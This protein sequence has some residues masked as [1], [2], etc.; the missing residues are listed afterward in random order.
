MCSRIDV[1]TLQQYNKT[2]KCMCAAY[3]DALGS[4]MLMLCQAVPHGVL[5]FFP[6]WG[7]LNAARDQWLVTGTPSPQRK[8]RLAFR[9]SCTSSLI[10]IGSGEMSWVISNRASEAVSYPSGMW[11]TSSSVAKYGC[12]YS[13][14]CCCTIRC[15][16]LAVSTHLDS[17][18]GRSDHTN[19]SMQCFGCGV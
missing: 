13:Y 9:W 6:S 12:R 8:A 14:H 5:C 15:S 3:L 10:C 7:L 17:G 19:N 11:H 2:S 1:T 4:A 18:V 16:M